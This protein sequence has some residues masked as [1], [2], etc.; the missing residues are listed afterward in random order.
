MC[1]GVNCDPEHPD[2][3]AAPDPKDLQRDDLWF[4][5]VRLLSRGTPKTINY[6]QVLHRAQVS[7]MAIYNAQSKGFV[8]TPVDWLEF[9]N[10]P[11]LPATY[12]APAE[13]ANEYVT[14]RNTYPRV[15]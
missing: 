4:F 15:P 14:V 12:R 13:L 2:Y 1:F 9:W 7:V 6:V 11:D 8:V 3:W 5:G 10:E